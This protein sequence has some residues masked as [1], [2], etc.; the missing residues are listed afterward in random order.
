M[1]GIYWLG[2]IA[3][4]AAEAIIF[5]LIVLITAETYRKTHAQASRTLIAFSS[6]MLLY[7]LLV[8]VTSVVFSYRYGS[9]VALPLLG[10]NT[11]SLVAFIAL[12][13]LISQ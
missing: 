11:I 7:S 12:Y 5:T 6:L 10:V 1:I 4:G 9:D 2:N 3:I 8:V 13:L